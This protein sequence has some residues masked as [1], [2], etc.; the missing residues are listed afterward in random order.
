MIVKITV[1]E[2]IDST[3]IRY[4]FVAEIVKTGPCWGL[5]VLP[6]EAPSCSRGITTRFA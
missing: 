3:P 4:F 1:N 6:L 2:E 5:R